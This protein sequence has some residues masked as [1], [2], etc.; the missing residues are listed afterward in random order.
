MDVEHIWYDW[1]GLGW[2]PAPNDDFGDPL[3]P[4]TGTDVY[5]GIIDV[6]RPLEELNEE[7][8]DDPDITWVQLADFQLSSG[9]DPCSYNLGILSS[10]DFVLF[11]FVASAEGT[12][13]ETIHQF[14]PSPPIRRPPTVSEWGLIVMALLLALAGT[15]AI[16]RRKQQIAA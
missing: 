8:Y 15:I 1:T 6:N 7:L 12:Q 16:V 14:Q 10:T 3:G 4:I 2:P 5:Y 13:T 11:R 9:A